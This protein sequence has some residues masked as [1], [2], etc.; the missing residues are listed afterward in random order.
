MCV[1]AP[2]KVENNGFSSVAQTYAHPYDL[3]AIELSAYLTVLDIQAQRG[4][5]TPAQKAA[6]IKNLLTQIEDVNSDIK[7]LSFDRNNANKVAD[8]VRGVVNGFS[9][10][11]LQHHVSPGRS[12][13]YADMKKSTMASIGVLNEIDLAPATLKTIDFAMAAKFAGLAAPVAPP[14]AAQAQVLKNNL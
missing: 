14:S 5:I 6:D 8:V 9:A 12:A 10:V 11:N 7:S 3:T 1:I 13:G 4:I 2:G